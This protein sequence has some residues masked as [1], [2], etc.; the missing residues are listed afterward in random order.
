MDAIVAKLPMLSEDLGQLRALGTGRRQ[1]RPLQRQKNKII[2]LY[3]LVKAA[4]DANNSGFESAFR[5]NP[6]LKSKLE[7]YTRDTVNSINDFLRMVDKD[8]IKAAEY[9]IIKPEDYFQNATRTIGTVFKTYDETAPEFDNLLKVR[10]E[11]AS[12]KRP[13][14]GS[15]QYLRSSESPISSLPSSC[16]LCLH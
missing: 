3:G 7:N 6:N 8:I 10:I 5:E 11:Q 16:Q 14:H 2:M 12:K 15:L 4:V 1:E 9:G 13:S